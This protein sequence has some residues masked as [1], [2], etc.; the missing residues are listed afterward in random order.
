VPER[1]IR[2]VLLGWLLAPLAIVLIASAIAS[3]A[4]ALT[5]TSAAYDRALLDP[6]LALAQRLTAAEGPVELDLPAVAIEMLRVDATDRVYFAARAGGRL[7]GGQA[8]LPPPPTLPEAGAPMFYDGA[9]GGEPV[10]VAAVLVPFADGPVLIQVAETLVKRHRLVRQLLLMNAANEILFFGVALAV[11]WIG[12]TRGLAPLDELR[13]ELAARSD[14]DLRPVAEAHAPT[15]VRPVVQELNRMLARLAGSIEAQQR[16]VA[17]AAHQLRTP[18]AALQAQVEAARP[19]GL[20]P[21]LAST[22]DRL[23]AATR[24]AAHLA[25]QLLTLA[26]IAPPA[27][28]PFS[29]EATDLAQVAQAGVTDWLARADRK[30][31]DLGFELAAAPVEGEPQLLGELAAN[32]LENALNYTPAGGEVT[33]RTG[34]RDG[35]SFLEVEDSGRG[36]PESERERVFE[37]FHRVPGTPGEGTGLG[38]AIVRE[39][40]HRHRAAVDIRTAASGVGT[41]VAVSFPAPPP[42]ARAG[43]ARPV[44]LG[45]AK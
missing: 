42:A 25:R 2:R 28:R 6:A 21:E 24:R 40:A 32:L 13:A 11:V 9:I 8:E 45:A 23:S 30:D 35:R 1:S 22:V 18:L 4:T 26:A 15:E 31:V 36:I 16:F 37:R 3:Y 43:L 17:D 19:E 20:P 41:V 33:V 10:R 14:R 39:I 38:L 5:L 29:A 34:R 12:V 7:L 44:G 27:E